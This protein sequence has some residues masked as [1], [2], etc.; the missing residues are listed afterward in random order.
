[1][2][3]SNY[4]LQ[5]WPRGGSQTTISSKFEEIKNLLSSSH[6]PEIVNSILVTLAKQVLCDGG[7][8]NVLDQYLEKIRPVINRLQAFDYLL[9]PKSS[10]TGTNTSKQGAHQGSSHSSF[11]DERKS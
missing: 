7:S 1:V 8:E 5:G 9:P 4:S 6:S 11:R 3:K 10:I 2:P